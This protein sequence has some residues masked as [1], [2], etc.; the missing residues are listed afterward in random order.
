M[1]RSCCRPKPR[2]SLRSILRSFI[3]LWVKLWHRNKTTCPESNPVQS[4]TGRKSTTCPRK[5]V[6]SD[7]NWTAQRLQM[8]ACKSLKTMSRVILNG[9]QPKF[10]AKSVAN[11]MRP[12]RGQDQRWQ[13][14]LRCSMLRF[15]EQSDLVNNHLLCYWPTIHN[16]ISKTCPKFHVIS[17][18]FFEVDE[19][20]DEHWAKLCEVKI[21]QLQSMSNA[22]RCIDHRFAF[23]NSGIACL[24]LIFN[25]NYLRSI[26]PAPKRAVRIWLCETV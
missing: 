18:H 15:F 6:C 8:A 9:S 23:K 5:G 17:S 14:E 11:E 16:S 13:D 26:I 1:A 7:S 10:A 19:L 12:V 24:A 22:I 3:G 25:L 20:L 2:P 21:F 4:S